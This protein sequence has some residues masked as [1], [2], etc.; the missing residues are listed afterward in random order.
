MCSRHSSHVSNAVAEARRR[1]VSSQYMLSS[2]RRQG[3]NDANLT[4][5]GAFYT[6]RPAYLF[7][8]KE[9]NTGQGIPY[10]ENI[11]LYSFRMLDIKS[12]VGRIWFLNPAQVW[13]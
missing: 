8:K 6:Y 5:Y 3:P 10:H 13:L 12:I 9:I 2:F 7:F 1:V 11:F 4:H